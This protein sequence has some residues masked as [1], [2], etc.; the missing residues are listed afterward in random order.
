MNPTGQ[1]V[2]P[3]GDNAAHKSVTRWPPPPFESEVRAA[4]AGAAP[5][6]ARGPGMNDRGLPDS[7]PEVAHPATLAQVAAQTTGSSLTTILAQAPSG[8]A[9]DCRAARAKATIRVAHSRPRSGKSRRDSLAERAAQF[10]GGR[11]RDCHEPSRTAARRSRRRRTKSQSCGS[12]EKPTGT[13]METLR[14]GGSRRT[15]G[16]HTALALIALGAQV[17][18]AYRR[19]EPSSHRRQLPRRTAQQ[20]NRSPSIRATVPRTTLIP[21]RIPRPR[22]RGPTLRPTVQ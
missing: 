8:V 13:R 5:H 22:R 12:R 7:R 14:Q 20:S 11:E 1:P 16:R 19:K 15:C 17:T 18:D 4:R 3:Q 9:D 2:S 6:A 10:K 21:R